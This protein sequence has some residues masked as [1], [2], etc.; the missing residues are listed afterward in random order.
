M[1]GII[2]WAESQGIR[3]KHDGKG[4][5][6]TTVDALNVALRIVDDTGP[7]QQWMVRFTTIAQDVEDP[8]LRCSL[9]HIFREASQFAPRHR[10][11]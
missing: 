4:G 2:R 10:L 11:D 9:P 8:S 1:A 6:W 3:Y 7:S 5:I